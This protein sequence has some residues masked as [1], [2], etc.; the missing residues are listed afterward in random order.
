MAEGESRSPQIAQ[1]NAEKKSCVPAP[2]A[3]LPPSPRPVRKASAQPEESLT[4]AQR[5]RE[6]AGLSPCA[7]CLRESQKQSTRVPTFKV[8]G[9]ISDRQKAVICLWAGKAAA[10]AGV[11]G[12]KAVE[13]WRR[14]EQKKAFGLESLTDAYQADYPK[15]KAHFE[16]L[17]KESGR[18]LN[19]HFRAAFNG[20]RQ[21]RWL[22]DKA[23]A[24]A[25]LQ[26]GYAAAI[27]RTQFKCDLDE[28]SETQ[29][30]MLL[31]TVRNRGAAKAEK[32]EPQKKDGPQ[33][34]QI[35]ADTEEGDPF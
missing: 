21:Y 2:I 13:E 9:G 20:K 28:A 6:E 35:N 19:T 34:S 3:Y 7:P 14:A 15:I 10:V 23:L 32:G 25:G 1:I 11:T 30:K 33:I 27:C 4:E 17:A 18:A 12:Y 22:L 26:T 24:E 5:H 16:S 8:K 29:L 31:F